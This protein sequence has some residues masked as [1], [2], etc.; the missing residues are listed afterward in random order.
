MKRD[1]FIKRIKENLESHQRQIY[2]EIVRDLTSD[3]SPVELAPELYASDEDLT[4][5]LQAIHEIETIGDA[6]RFMR[7]YAYDVAGAVATAL[8]ILIGDV[9]EDEFC[10][11][12]LRGWDT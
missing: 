1:E 4:E 7:E 9:R 3:H 6:F 2:S 10:A 11:V 12:P 8:S 5:S